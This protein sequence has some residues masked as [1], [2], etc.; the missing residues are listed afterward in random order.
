MMLAST[1]ASAYSAN[2][3]GEMAMDNAKRDKKI[4]AARNVSDQKTTLRNMGRKREQ[5]GYELSSIKARMSSSGLMTSTG[6]SSDFVEKATERLELGILDEAEAQAGRDRGSRNQQDAVIY[7]GKT[8]KYQG[9]MAA[10][11]ELVKGGVKIAQHQQS[12]AAK[13]PAPVV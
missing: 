10:I 1:A 4:L 11:G 3:K 7:K 6:S 13:T 5:S 8:A 2:K 12:M 9:R